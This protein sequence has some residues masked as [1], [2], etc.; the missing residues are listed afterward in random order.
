MG[1]GG[2][3]ASAPEL[4]DGGE[5]AGMFSG[6]AFE[7]YDMRPGAPPGAGGG[8]MPGRGGGAAPGGPGGGGIPSG[9]AGGGMPGGQCC[10]GAPGNP[11]GGGGAPGGNPC[12][13]PRARLRYALARISA[14]ACQAAVKM[15][16]GVLAPWRTGGGGGPPEWPRLMDP[17][18]G[19]R[20]A[21]PGGPPGRG[22]GGPGGK[23]PGGGGAWNPPCP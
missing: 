4:C 21:P 19:T 1:D 8:G 3:P 13:S 5:T 12:G 20:G 11:P 14:A 7:G 2:M 9:P 18:A 23:P 10:P 15:C 17:K 22:G 6:S 16:T